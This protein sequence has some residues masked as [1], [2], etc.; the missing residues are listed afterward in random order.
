MSSDDAFRKALDLDERAAH[1]RD[2]T[3][4]LA[5]ATRA[6]VHATL[7]GVE[8]QRERWEEVDRRRDEQLTEADTD[9]PLSHPG[10]APLGTFPGEVPAPHPG[11][12]TGALGRASFGDYLGDSP[13]RRT[14][15]VD[16]L[17]VVDR[18]GETWRYLG[19]GWWLESADVTRLDT[20]DLL[21]EVG[22]CRVV[23]VPAP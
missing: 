16:R 15:L 20:I 23:W 1:A 10:M 8:Q 3:E 22:P 7:A 19:D 4:R 17:L 9:R 21:N 14:P 2:A 5:H 6:L 12:R 13:G 11:S 18:N